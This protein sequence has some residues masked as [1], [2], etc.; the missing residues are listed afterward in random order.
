MRP[1]EE[2]EEFT[3]ATKPIES[4]KSATALRAVG[5]LKEEEEEFTMATRLVKSNKKRFISVLEQKFFIFFTGALFFI[6]LVAIQSLF[7]FFFYFFF[8]KLLLFLF[9]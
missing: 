8:L 3:M 4:I 1:A 5:R 2:E 6:C 9:F 7:I